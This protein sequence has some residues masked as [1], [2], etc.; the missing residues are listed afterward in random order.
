[1][2]Q[3]IES[4]NAKA[5][6]Y[7]FSLSF[8]TRLEEEKTTAANI[9]ITDKNG[10]VATM[11]EPTMGSS[12]HI[13]AFYDDFRTVEHLTAYSTTS[14]VRFDFEPTKAGFIK[15]FVQVKIAGKELTI[16]F[17][18]TIPPGEE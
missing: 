8:D 2:M 10:A 1:M 18:V 4:L 12:A 3:K 11:L 5:G 17:G 7:N 16:P 13:I 9:H 14:G 6:G 15:L